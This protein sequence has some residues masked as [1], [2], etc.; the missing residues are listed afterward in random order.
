MAEANSVWRRNERQATILASLF[1]KRPNR[2]AAFLESNKKKK[3][4]QNGAVQ[5]KRCRFLSNTSFVVAQNLGG[6]VKAGN[7]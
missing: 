1:N 7:I 6:K 3:S 4:N 5:A 2:N